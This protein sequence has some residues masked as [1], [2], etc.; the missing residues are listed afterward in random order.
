M[1]PVTVDEKGRV[2][3]PRALREQYGIAKGDMLWFV[4]TESGLE[5]RPAAPP[6]E[7]LGPVAQAVLAEFAAGTTRPLRTVM[8]EMKLR[9]GKPRTSRRTASTAPNGRKAILRRTRR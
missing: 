3:L 6:A 1:K 8:A 4:A 9:P 7:G 5:L 2:V